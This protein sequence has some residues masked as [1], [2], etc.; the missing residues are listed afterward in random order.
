M[1]RKQQE[2]YRMII[3]QMV[4]YN[5]DFYKEFTIKRI[6][7]I[8]DNDLKILLENINLDKDK[9]I[10]KK[11]YM[12]YT[13]FIYYADKMID[14]MVNNSMRIGIS[15]VDELYNKRALLLKTIENQTSTIK[16]RNELIENL[17]N[18]VLMFKDNGKNILDQ[19]DYYIISKF[20]FFNFFD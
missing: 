17:N 16:E 8:V 20:G 14:S 19:C 3:N 18:K 9:I 7:Q 6:E 11:G 13:K 4:D 10:K 12:T 15:K 1:T 2:F 5:E